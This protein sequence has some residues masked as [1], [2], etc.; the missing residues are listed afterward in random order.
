MSSSY[1]DPNAGRSPY[2]DSSSFSGGPFPP[3]QPYAPPP[4]KGEAPAKK[5]GWGCLGCALGCLGII[6]VLGI[7]AGIGTWY[8]IK[9]LPEIARQGIHEMIKDSDLSEDDKRVVMQQVDRLVDGYKDGR[10]D[11]QQLARF[12]EDFAQSPLMDLLIAFGAKVQYIEKSGLT[13]DEKAE[14]E[15]T[16]QRVAR[17]VIEEKIE[18]E[19]LDIA[20]NH[21]SNEQPNGA[22]QFKESVSDEELRAFLSECKKLADEA[23]IPDEDVQVDIG[24][25]LK[26]LVDKTLGELPDEPSESLPAEAEP[27][28]AT[29]P[30]S[31]EKGNEPAEK[32]T[33]S[34]AKT[35]APAAE[36]K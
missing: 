33:D 3:A 2:G 26:K 34:E 29:P 19:K 14:A 24:K 13:P 28:D 31:D 16:L 17:G 1:N 36:E 11:M 18:Q 23:Q 9:Q 25:E 10:I 21:I 6:V 35:T 15:K 22:R 30:I 4:G 8:F 5:S 32:G 7:A 27:K 20:L 12:A